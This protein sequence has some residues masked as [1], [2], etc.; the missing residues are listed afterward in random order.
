MSAASELGRWKHGCDDF[1][2]IQRRGSVLG[3]RGEGRCGRG[4]YLWP[5]KRMGQGSGE[6]SWSY[7]GLHGRVLLEHEV[8]ETAAAWARHVSQPKREEGPLLGST[9]LGHCELGRPTQTRARRKTAAAHCAERRSR[10]IRRAFGP[11]GEKVS[12]FFFFS[13]FFSL[14]V[15]FQTISNKIF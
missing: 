4:Y 3:R 7:I 14:F 12:H 2:V 11:P 5:A 10:P 15:C 8:E 1:P 9:G 13:S 6:G